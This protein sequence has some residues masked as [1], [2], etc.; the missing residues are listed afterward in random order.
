MSESRF[1]QRIDV[2]EMFPAL[3]E[4]HMEKLDREITKLEKITRI[5]YLNERRIR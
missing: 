2:L 1:T 5:H 3:H 4:D